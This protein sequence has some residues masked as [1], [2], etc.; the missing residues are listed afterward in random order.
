MP[1]TDLAR[2]LRA[3]SM[4]VSSST[5]LLGEAGLLGLGRAAQGAEMGLHLDDLLLCLADGLLQLRDL[6]GAGLHHAPGRLEFPLLSVELAGRLDLP[7]L[8][9]AVADLVFFVL[10]LVL[11]S[12]LEVA[13]LF[14][15]APL[16]HEQLLELLQVAVEAS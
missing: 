8:G 1:C 11:L 6:A 7:Q 10:K 4:L 16:C 3:L 14:E 5:R 9:L 13:S 2:S 12:R 15:L